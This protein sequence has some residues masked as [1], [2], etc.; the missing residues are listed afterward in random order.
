MI[1]T[2][3]VRS[4][5]SATLPPRCPPPAHHDPALWQDHPPANGRIKTMCRVCG[6]FVGYRPSKVRPREPIV[7]VGDI[8]LAIEQQEIFA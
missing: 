8:Q 7:D 1:K 3:T 2:Q 4:S 5:V 6:G